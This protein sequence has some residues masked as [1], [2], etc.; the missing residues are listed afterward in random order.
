MRLRTA[1]LIAAAALMMSM[2]AQAENFSYRYVDLAHLPDAGIDNGDF[3]VNGD[4]LQLRGS[5]P[6]YQNFFVLA[7]LQDLNF[8]NGVDSTRVMIGAGGHWPV[9]NTVD[10]IARAGVVDY[11]VDAGSF[12]D[13]DTGLFIGARLR[14]I[15]APRVELEGG[16][17]HLNV[18]VAGLDNDTYLVGEGRYNFTPQWSAGVLLTIGGDTNIF[19]VH[20]RYSF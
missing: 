6:F 15:V 13:D 17:E 16:I 10:I 3:D 18:K 9:N 5:L 14:A 4:G 1:T 2:A 19:G 11:K 12:D 7:E 8:D 20:G